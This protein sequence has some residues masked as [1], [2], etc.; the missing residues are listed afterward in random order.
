MANYK[1]GL[2]I[3]G[4]ASG[5]IRAIKATDDELG[6][7]NKNFDR[8][9]RQ[10]KR[11]GSDAQR[12]GRQLSVIDQGATDASR[13]LA[14]LRTNVAGVAAAMATAFG[15]GSVIN[16]ARLIADTDALAKSIGVATG[17]LQAWDYA[18]Q[19]MGMSGGQIGDILK[20][21]TE[22]IGE[23]SAEG[24]GE[25]AALFENLNLNI[26]EMERLAPDEQ[27][28]K[29][30]DAISTLE[31]RGEKISYLE[32]L[33]NDATRLLPLLDDNAALLREYS[34]EAEALGVSMSR[35]DIDNAVEANRAMRQLGGT[36]EGFTNQIVAD[37]GPGLADAVG[38]L[39]DFIQ[40][41]GG[42][43]VILTNVKDV[44]ILTAAVMAGRYAASFAAS[45][46]QLIEKNAAS[47]AAVVAE[48]RTLQMAV[49]RAAAE[50]T[51]EKR[52]LGRA[53][54]EERATRGTDAHTAALA[55][56][57]VARSRSIAAA[58]EHTAA[59]NANTAATQRS[60]VAARAASGAYAL[61]GGP[62]GAATLAATAFFMFRDSSD[63]VSE[64]LV[65]LDQ[66]LESVIDD[67]KE[68]TAES[69]RAA[70]IK[71]GDRQ[72]E[73]ADKARRALTKIREEVLNLGFEGST[74]AEAREFFDEVSAGFEAVEDGAQSLDGMLSGLQEQLEIPDS[75]MRNLRLLASEYSEG[76]VAADE[77]G[78]RLEALTST[79]NDVGAAA[80]NTG[81]QVEDN[82]P[83]DEAIQKWE[84]YNQKLRESVAA[85]QDPSATGAASR[86]L[87]NLGIEDPVRRATTLMLAA[88][89]DQIERQKELQKEAAD[90]ARQAA[91]DAKN[92]AQQQARAAEQQANSLQAVQQE[93]DPLL[94]D[95]ATYIERMDVLD[96]ALADGT[97]TQEAYGEAVRW[98]AE[99]FSRAATGA[100]DYEKQTERLIDQ[101]DSHNQKAAQLRD[102]VDGINERYRAGEISGDQYTRMIGGV[103][104]E[105]QELALEADPAAQ[106]MARAWEEASNRIDETFADAFTGAF[107]SFDEFGDQLL[108]SF[109][110]L[111]GELAYQATLKPIVVN[112]TSA[113]GGSLGIPGAGGQQS[114]GL[115]GMGWGDMLSAGKSIYSGI[116]GVGPA[117]MSGYQS[118]GLSGAFNGG[119]GYYGDMASGAYNSAAGA[120]GY[121]GSTAA[122]GYGGAGWAGSATGAYGGW[123]GSATAGAGS[124]GGMSG[125]L[126][127]AA[128]AWPLAVAMGMYQSGKLYDAGVRPDA[129]ETWDSTQ[130]NT[131]GQIGNVG[132]T[133]MS[134]LFEGIDSV[135]EPLVGGKIAAVLS[136]STFHQALWGGINKGLFGGSWETKDTGIAL[137]ASGA[138]LNAQA[139]ADQKKDGGWFGSDKTRTRY[140]SLES[141]TSAELQAMYDNTINGVSGYFEQ[142]GHD[143]DRAALAGLDI[144]RKKFNTE[145]ATDEEIEAFV[146]EW[147]GDATESITKAMGAGSGLGN[148]SFEGLVD[149]VNDF[150]SVNEVVDRLGVAMLDVS[151]A[152]AKAAQSLLDLTGGME[153]LNQGAQYYYENYVS[154]ADKQEAAMDAAARAM[155]VFTGRTGRVVRTTDQLTDLVD[156]LDLNTSAGRELYAAAMELAPALVEVEAGLERVRDRFSEMLSEAENALGS[157]E[158]STLSA[159]QTFDSQSYDQ[160]RQLLDM[161]G[162]SEAALALERERELATIDE[163]LRPT[164]ERIWALEDEAKAVNDYASAL[165]SANTFLENALDNI[166]S[167]VDQRRATTGAPSENLQESQ[168]QFAR[169]L[170]LAEAGDRDALQSITEYADR[171]LSA[172]DD[173]YASG[174]G[175]QSV[176]A[177]VMDAISALPDALSPEDY[178][179]QDIK[180]ALE[181][182]ENLSS[183]PDLKAL[184]GDQLGALNSLIAEMRNSTDQFVSLDSNMV[185]LRD[186]INALGVAREE[187]A[188]IERERAAAEKAER[189]RLAREREAAAEAERE[190]IAM[191]KKQAAIAEEAA[192][193]QA[194]VAKWDSKRND[195]TD[196]HSRPDWQA[197]VNQELADQLQNKDWIKNSTTAELEER[198]SGWGRTEVFSAYAARYQAYLADAEADLAAI[199]KEY[200][201]LG[202]GAAPFA[203][204]GVFTNSI[205]SRPTH[206]D[207]GLMGEAG[208]EAIV[209]LHMGSDG[210]GIK[211]YADRRLPMP[212]MPLPEFPALGSNDVLQVLQDVKKVLAASR[213]ENKRLLEQ[214][215]DNTGN[216]VKAISGTATK[217]E[218]QRAAQLKEQQ[219]ATRAAKVKGRSV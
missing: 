136:G 72:E 65:S 88:Q 207:M 76:R 83:S 93:M 169:Q 173:Y 196:Q 68:L 86:E 120:L 42:A 170:T 23:F 91:S 184:A 14:L 66:P 158:Q 67:F 81:S 143:V 59:V 152:G 163:S 32:R 142:I 49:R 150:T 209:P 165:E 55:R 213:A 73:E 35:V 13:G 82:T 97:I 131:L 129:G 174:D 62:L 115:G 53:V 110:R 160:Q 52:M 144:A 90:A 176:E 105:M 9:S 18:A 181:N 33:G 215:G 121:G 204:G 182:S 201:S 159:W 211:N 98:S 187:V 45:T 147:F 63:E 43:E 2:I 28:L 95:H 199:R 133:A 47:A 192:A 113:M 186:S 20:D 5:G 61:I 153:G 171:Y 99:Q 104:D 190:R 168:A 141:E 57:N 193:A 7:L 38:G 145:D 51:A 208:P 216:T 92:A 60:T 87:D 108:D 77:L 96:K 212:D 124:A 178:I 195:P 44:A 198:I 36:M 30:A 103:R 218:Q 154:E 125:A 119:V 102:A 161:M 48:E 100:E 116:T 148:L 162:N 205:V 217:A 1:T 6:K 179:A 27:L 84:Q 41:M 16:Q 202:G 219:A 8:G 175:Y 126:S 172:A 132:P 85:Q 180:D 140:E 188:R 15:A 197:W 29:I 64:S 123:A 185:S 50:A 149:L 89:Q 114:G 31:T 71:W 101:Y 210:L 194:R 12:A 155:G 78:G 34:A 157:A 183:L 10:S 191:Q 167:W 206:F 117:V 17:Q 134:G 3:T 130:G 164:Q 118:G 39:T 22:R 21:I 26:A 135:L 112:F 151:P 128:S 75:V 138:N 19:Q 200:E 146:T 40:E 54:A 37:L 122:A 80:E 127:S 79:F 214:I 139:Y 94:A 156:G 109:K 58:T 177:D 106:E 25:A 69:Q 46:K 137:G 11:F 203:K 166:A 56:L 111:L 24:T 189:E 70:L 74:G 107:D 4:D